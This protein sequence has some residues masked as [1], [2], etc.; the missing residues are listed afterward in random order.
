M[1]LTPTASACHYF[2]AEIRRLRTRLGWSTYELGRRIHQSPDLVRKVEVAI[3]VPSYE[4]VKNCDHVLAADGLLTSMW[5]LLQRERRIRLLGTEVSGRLNPAAD[6]R[7]VLDWLLTHPQPRPSSR[8]LAAGGDAADRLRRLRHID[9]LHGAGRNHT[10][11]TDLMER[12]LPGLSTTAPEIAIGYLELAGYQAV[13][14]GHD[15]QAQ[16]HYLDALRLAAISD[17]R[18]YG[19]YIVGVSL[20]HLALHYGDPRHAARLTEAALRGLDTAESSPAVR[21]ACRAVLARA[22]ARLGDERAC[23][24]ALRHAETD[25]ERSNPAL[26]PPWIAYYGPADLADEIAGALLD[27]G[28][29]EHAH[30]QAATAIA[31]LDPIR[32]RR[33]AIEHALAATALARSAKIDEACHA[34]RQ[35]IE[36]AT[37]TTSFLV[38]HR[39]TM[40]LAEFQPHSRMSVVGELRE[41]ASASLGRMAFST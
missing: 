14:L 18:L 25:L 1:P 7:A 8:L 35:A 2:G 33:L 38:M 37:R 20:A 39:M 27:L 26:E 28:R 32:V 31:L 19:A 30:Q 34:A 29:H 10:D 22:H 4:F 40:L 36:H 9:H 23:T 16:R 3:R 11:V 17:D 41:L 24:A 15:E 21:A 6:D 13:D 12:D 5:A